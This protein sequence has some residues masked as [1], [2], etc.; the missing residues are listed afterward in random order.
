MKENFFEKIR[1][2]MIETMQKSLKNIRFII[3]TSTQ[4]LGNYIG[5]PRQTIAN[6]EQNLET[7]TGTQYLAIAALLDVKVRENPSIKDTLVLALRSRDKQYTNDRL[8]ND[9][10]VFS[11]VDKWFMT[12]PIQERRELANE[13]ALDFYTMTMIANNYKIFINYDSLMIGRENKMFLELLQMMKESNNSLIVP[14]RV[15]DRLQGYIFSPEENKRDDARRALTFLNTLRENDNIVLRGE[16]NDGTIFEVMNKVFSTLKLTTKLVLI[17]QDRELSKNL[18]R[19]NSQLKGFS[20]K[21]L[22]LSDRDKIKIYSNKSVS[23][24]VE[25]KLQESK[26]HSTEAKGLS[27]ILSLNSNS[28]NPSD[29]DDFYSEDDMYSEDGFSYDGEDSDIVEGSVEEG[30]KV[31]S[32]Y[33]VQDHNSDTT[34]SK[35]KDDDVST[36]IKSINSDSKS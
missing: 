36:L 5:V 30:V 26:S 13:E 22:E 20:I 15:V 25:T 3:G 27:E 33:K 34:N 9:D 1:N 19:L 31:S 7:M 4:E 6:M 11:F 23:T 21:I 16:E 24:L 17:T 14:L 10:S 2:N 8:N 32:T 12:F 35:P 29:E 18:L 28:N